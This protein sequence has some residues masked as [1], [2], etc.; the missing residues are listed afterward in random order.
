MLEVSPQ[1]LLLDANVNLLHCAAPLLEHEHPIDNPPVKLNATAILREGVLYQRKTE[2]ELSSYSWGYPFKCH[3]TEYKEAELRR[4]LVERD[5]QD[6]KERKKLVQQVAEE[7]KNV[8]HARSK[9]Q[10]SKHQIV[11]EVTE[12]S[13]ELLRQAVEEEE[14]I[15]QKRCELIQQI[16]AIE[17][18]PFLKGKFVDLT[19]TAD[20]RVFGE[21]S[22]VELR[23]RLAL[24]KEAQKKTEEEKRDQIIHEKHAKEQLLL[25][26]L[27]Q[28]SKFREAFGRTAALKQEEKKIKTRVKEGLLKDERV[29]DLQKKVEEKSMERKIQTEHLKNEKSVRP[30]KS[31]KKFSLED[32]W[33]DLEASRQRQFK[34][35]QH[36]FMSR[37]LHEK[38]TASEAGKIGTTACIL[39]S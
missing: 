24:L 5:L 29:L 14:E 25:D 1:E 2:Q 16:R 32:H 33:K 8:K 10:K 15:Y 27:E 7:R 13:R 37:E 36:D 12:E 9:L 6:K 30:W 4:Q 35:F 19:Q 23:E 18:V 38:M 26:K 39:R 17:H 3:F 11:Q 20:H 21:M 28:I 31:Q 34:A 22:I